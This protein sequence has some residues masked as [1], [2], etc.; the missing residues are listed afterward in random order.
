MISMG[1]KGR[2]TRTDIRKTGSAFTFASGTK[3][4]APGQLSIE[5]LFGILAEEM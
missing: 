2:R 5:E 4:S 3:A 1:S